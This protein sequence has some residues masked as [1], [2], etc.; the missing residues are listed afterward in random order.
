[1]HGRAADR[2]Y[3]VGVS[4]DT[5]YSL[6]ALGIGKVGIEV[7]IIQ[8]DALGRCWWWALFKRRSG[9]AGNTFPFSR[10]KEGTDNSETHNSPPP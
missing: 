9:L 5:S 10:Q 2:L 1:M 7:G 6:E 8:K 3:L 4:S